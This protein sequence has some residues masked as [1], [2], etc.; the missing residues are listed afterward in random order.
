MKKTLLRTT[1]VAA[2]AMA[3]SATPASAKFEVGISGYME[4]WFGY[5]DNSN[6]ANPD[7]DVFDQNSDIVIA[8]GFSQELDNGLEIGGEVGFIGTG[9]GGIDS[10]LLY[11]EG[12]F[13]QLNLGTGDDA[14]TAMHFG[15]ISNGIGLDDGD[16][17]TVWVAGAAG[18]LSITSTTSNVD[19]T[20]NKVTY[21]SPR[22]NGVQLGVSYIPEIGD[23]DARVP[24]TGGLENNTFRDNSVSV[25]AN[26]ENTFDAMSFKVSVGYADGGTDLS[27]IGSEDALSAGVQLGFG[28]FTASFAY[29]EHDRDDGTPQNVNTFGASLAYNAGPAGVSLAYLRGEDSPSDD[30][31]DA[32]EVGANIEIGPGI[33]ASTSLYYVERVTAGST[34]ADGVAVVGGLTLTF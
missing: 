28:G 7:S 30:K 32:I 18:P 22:M 23:T 8:V 13:G 2:L 27:A 31:Q 34:T 20:S 33:T 25:G 1:S 17:A 29:G 14:A 15:V 26:Y 11:V 16:A 21:F 3:I 10:Q 9:G 5:S 6:S 4:Q 12:S 19:N 24:A